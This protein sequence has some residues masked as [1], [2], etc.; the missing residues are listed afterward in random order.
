MRLTGAYNQFIY[1]LWSPVYDPVTTRFFRRGR[2]QAA[3]AAGF[4]PG[5][6]VLLVGVG[7]GADLPL[8]PPGV[9]A[10]GIDLSEAMLARARARLPLPGRE[11]TLQVGDAEALPFPDGAF[12]AVLLH[13]ILSVV[14][15]PRRCM[16]EALRVLRPGGR[17]VVFDKFLPDGA[18]PRLRRRVA[19]ACSTLLGTDINRRLGEMVAGLPCEVARDEP[20]LLGGMY[21]VVLLRR[22]AAA[23]PGTP[24]ETA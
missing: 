15:E 22:G 19:N 17:A 14:P 12:D 11:I 10:V 24:A 20:S 3:A 9:R 2:D 6:R 16:G 5:E 1:R 8:L 13:L 21:R 7:T 23:G 18:G 4:Q